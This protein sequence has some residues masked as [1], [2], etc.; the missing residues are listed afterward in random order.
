MNLTHG[1]RCDAE[2]VRS[3]SPVDL[4]LIYQLQVGLVH[5]A[6]CVQRM[7]LPFLTHLPLRHLPQFVI[8]GC[9]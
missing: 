2:E 3:V 8:D 4:S 5:E 1:P 9:Q 6:R 7:A